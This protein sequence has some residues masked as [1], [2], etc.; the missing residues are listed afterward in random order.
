VLRDYINSINSVEFN[1]DE[2]SLQDLLKKDKYSV[3]R[4]LFE[5]LL[6]VPATSA[7]VERILSS[8]GLI[9]RLHR[10]KISD[11][12]VETLVFIKCNSSLE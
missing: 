3:I 6:C 2:L 8:S 7:P 12:L 11:T 1:I 4:P 10:A 9:M 5:R